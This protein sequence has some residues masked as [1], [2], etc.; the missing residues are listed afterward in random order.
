M[1]KTFNL[2]ILFL[3]T[4]ILFAQ[5]PQGVNY[6]AVARD[7]NALMTNQNIDVRFAIRENS[8][9]GPLIFEETHST[10]TNQYGLFALVLGQGNVSTGDF[11]MIEWNGTDHFLEV[12]IDTG[13]GFTS[14][15]ANRF[16]SVPYSLFADK[17]NMGLEDLT[18][19]TTA[20]PNNG[21]V[22]K[23]NGSEWAAAADAGGASYTAGNGININGSTIENAAPDQVVNI[24]GGGAT[25]VSG[26][27]PNFT[28]N[29]TTYTAGNGIN[30]NGT[31]ITNAAPD[32]VVSL[33]GSGATTVSGTYPNFTINSTDNNT[34]YTAGS[35]ISISGTTINNTAPDQVIGLTGTGAA[36]VSGNYPNFTINATDNNTTYTAGAGL[37]LSGTTFVNT[38]DTDA[39]DD[40]TNA[41]TAG[42]DVSG[43]FGGLTV[44]GIQ[45]ESVS[46]A[47]PAIG[48]VLKWDGTQWAVAADAS[49]GSSLWNQSGQT[50]NYNTGD[51]GIGTSNPDA[52]LEV[53][54]NGS[55]TDPQLQLHEN[56]N[57][58]ARI[59]MQNNNGTNYWSIAAYVASNVRNDRLNFWNGTTGDILTLTG[60]GEMGLN[61]GISPKTSFHVGNGHRVL[62]GTDTLGPGDKLMWLPDLHAFRVGAVSTGAASTYWNRDSIG[63]YSFATGLNTRAQGYA[64]TALG[65]DT[66]ATNSYAFAS[67]FFTNADGLYSTAMGFNTDAL[68]LG[69][70]ALG[71]STDAEANYSF[72]VGYFAD[73]E[74]I[75]STAIGNNVRAQSFS[76]TAVG[77]YNVGGGNAASW[78]TS[79]PLFEIGNGTGPSSRSNAVTVRKNGNVGI[80]T[81]VP[82]DRLHVNGRIRMATVEY[83]EDGGTSEIAARGDLRPTIDNT[84]D[85]GTSVLRYDDVFATSGIVNTSDRRDKEAI[86]PIPYGLEEI[87]QLNPVRYRWKNRPLS[88]PKL[89]LIAQELLPVISEV[90]KTHDLEGT[91]EN[92]QD[93][94]KV[95]LE[96]LGVYYSDLI[97]VLIKGMQEQQ[98]QIERLEAE[99]ADL[100]KQ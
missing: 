17:A 38:G 49:G 85:I 6:Q 89:G 7:G 43:T 92:P 27:Y 78:I 66:E 33:N 9:S 24:N 72:A 29:S 34:T 95:E 74:A 21:D 46:P 22:L 61:V 30:I 55:L 65:R 56:G 52:S 70:T 3:N 5:V 71:Y 31:A 96:R 44:T 63:L 82:L 80:G 93:F 47:I 77:R 53:F 50:I 68:A 60:D 23:W 83:F 48:D 10:Q 57:D 40:I 94:H 97:P 2:L 59:R 76:S 18:N 13:N 67:G 16:E 36:S 91:E 41:S 4:G 84:Y 58:Y 100:K 88:E 8:I 54:S 25:T 32:Q 37:N 19:V 15:G 69:A 42:G 99:I 35:D 64:S 45:G 62:F 79:D 26:T 12:F 1:K 51:V 90:V 39:S 28:I 14:M 75:Y 11:S 98:V 81:T 86:E 73:A 20:N 87:M